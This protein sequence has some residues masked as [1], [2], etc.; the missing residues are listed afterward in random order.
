LKLLKLNRDYLLNK[1]GTRLELINKDISIGMVKCTI[2]RL[3]EM[4]LFMNHL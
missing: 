3:L 1:L 2:P 4:I